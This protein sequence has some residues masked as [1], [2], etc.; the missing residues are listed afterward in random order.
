MANVAY[1][2]VEVSGSQSEIKEFKRIAFESESKA[3]C[4]EKLLP[5]PDYIDK[6]KD[7]LE[8]EAFR[9]I[10]Y[11][12]RWG[13]GFAILTEESDLSLT[14]FFN[15]KWSEEIIE[16]NLCFVAFKFQSLKFSQYF[17]DEFDNIGYIQ[18]ENGTKKE[19]KYLSNKGFNWNESVPINSLIFLHDI[20][21]KFELIKKKYSNSDRLNSPLSSSS[22]LDICSFFSIFP[23]IKY[24]RESEDFYLKLYNMEKDLESKPLNYARNLAYPLRT[25]SLDMKLEFITNCLLPSNKRDIL[26][27]ELFQKIMLNA[28][29]N[30]CDA[31]NAIHYIY[32]EMDNEDIVCEYAKK[33]IETA[34]CRIEHFIN[35]YDDFLLKIKNYKG[36]LPKYEETSCMLSKG[37]IDDLPSLDSYL[38]KY[39]KALKR[40]PKKEKKIDKKFH[41][42]YESLIV[43]N[44][45]NHSK[46]INLY[47]DGF[48]IDNIPKLDSCLKKYY[49][50]LKRIPKKEKKT[51]KKFHKE[52]ESLI[53]MEIKNKDKLITT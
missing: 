22:E 15:S 39:Y 8:L 46:L 52:Y 9:K 53:A 32:I 31:D 50:A 33:W 14:Y 27:R 37:F 10:I 24:L 45:K 26:I 5:I 21:R 1:N 30:N 6:D 7:K 16:A 25:L 29:K 11:G 51:D 12:N 44:E 19:H 47:F 20:K 41:K 49:E 42:E 36:V 34:I 43:I 13:N 18:Y 4:F 17:A 35:N 2:L 3:F 48:F 40:I 28:D 38:K 23:K